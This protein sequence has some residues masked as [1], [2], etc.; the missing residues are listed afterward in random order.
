MR[1]L[2]LVLLLALAGSPALAQTPANEGPQARP[3]PNTPHDAEHAPTGND[4]DRRL[5]A[6]KTDADKGDGTTG[7]DPGARTNGNATG[8]AKDMPAQTKDDAEHAPTRKP[9]DR[10]QPPVPR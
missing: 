10:E 8:R 4:R 9:G 5:P 3:I 1:H 7:R 2:P 6:A